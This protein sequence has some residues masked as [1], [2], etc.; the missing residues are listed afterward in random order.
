VGTR[1]S[2]SP[3]LLSVLLLAGCTAT[4]T[5]HEV[6]LSGQ[7]T[8]LADCPGRWYAAG[9][10]DGAPALWTSTDATHWSA[11]P[12]HPVSAYGPVQTLSAVACTGGA[13]VAVGSA[14]GGVHGN[15][16]TSTWYGTVGGPLTEVPSPFELFGGP[17]AIGVERVLVGPAGWLITGART[18]ANGLVGAAVWH[19]DDGRDFRLVDADPALEST[20]DSQT[21]A[22]G[23]YAGPDG[24][25]VVGSTGLAAR[26]PLVW[27]SPDGLHWHRSPVPAPARD[28]EIQRSTPD[29]LAVGLAGTGFAAWY[30]G[31]PTG[32]FGT[33][34]GTGLAAVTDLVAGDALVYDGE[35]Y[36][37]WSTT[38]HGAHWT[39]RD[40]PAQLGQGHAALAG[41]LLTLGDR[42]WTE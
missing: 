10:R 5:W 19:S 28:A 7:V 26:T 2:W 13:V 22:F 18:D 8:A 40:L 25:T 31:R 11:V 4:T 38:D 24:Y 3:I 39:R 1:S 9:A 20:V 17:R 42:L 23:G 12:V 37:L 30:E 33:F 34:H 27:T 32:T 35:A 6:T 15:L 14:A 36:Q 41:H 21:V 16:R 29:G